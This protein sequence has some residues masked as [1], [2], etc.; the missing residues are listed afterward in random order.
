MADKQRPMSDTSREAAEL[1]ASVHRRLTGPQRLGIAWDMSLTARELSL[2]RL[3][4]E[5]PEWSDSDLKR[6]LLRIAFLPG[7]LPLP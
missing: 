4:A 7:R 1:Q 3:R 2:S 5:H 6:E